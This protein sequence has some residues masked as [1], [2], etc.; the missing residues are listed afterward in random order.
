MLEE[1]EGTEK[2]QAALAAIDT[3]AQDK[4]E[5]ASEPLPKSYPA[6]ALA[7][8]GKGFVIRVGLPEWGRRLAAGQPEVRQLTRNIADLIRGYKPKIHTS[9][10]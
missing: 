7:R 10:G 6:L 5:A 1:S 2:V 8:V 3:K 9:Y 4:A